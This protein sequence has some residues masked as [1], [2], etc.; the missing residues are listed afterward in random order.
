MKEALELFLKQQPNEDSSLGNLE[1]EKIAVYLLKLKQ[2]RPEIKVNISYHPF[3]KSMLTITDL[4][5][6][7]IGDFILDHYL[8]KNG[9][10]QNDEYVH[11]DNKFFYLKIRECGAWEITD[12][13]HFNLQ[14]NQHAINPFR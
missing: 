11:F 7:V 13:L 8:A 4:N 1:L 12:I 2:E 6:A 5:S 3:L 14:F 10:W 9:T